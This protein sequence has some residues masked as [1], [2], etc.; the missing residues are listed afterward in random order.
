M[1]LKEFKRV[2]HKVREGQ[3]WQAVIDYLKSKKVKLSLFNTYYELT[4]TNPTLPNL[5]SSEPQRV[6]QSGERKPKMDD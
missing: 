3:R 4:H 6:Q 2:V 1:N 5:T